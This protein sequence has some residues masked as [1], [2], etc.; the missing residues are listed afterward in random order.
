MT[1]PA[2]LRVLSRIAIVVAAPLLLHA[3]IAE[4]QKKFTPTMIV[5]YRAVGVVKRMHFD[6]VGEVACIP[7]VTADNIGNQVYGEAFPGWA[8]VSAED[9][10][11]VVVRVQAICLGTEVSDSDDLAD[12]FIFEDA[13]KPAWVQPIDHED[14]RFHIDRTGVRVAGNGKAAI[15]KSVERLLAFQEVFCIECAPLQE[16]Y[17]F[18]FWQPADDFRLYRSAANTLAPYTG[19]EPS[20]FPVRLFEGN[21]GDLVAAELSVV[22]VN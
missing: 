17:P 19:P 7:A 3:C 4:V 16:G 10:Q 8:Q 22:S 13:P 15:R 20:G 5:T 14:M 18:Q 12:A 6:V 9:G 2:P 1:R 21:P 11:I